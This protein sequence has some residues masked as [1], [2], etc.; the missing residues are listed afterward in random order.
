MQLARR[1]NN[2]FPAGVLVAVAFYGTRRRIT[3]VLNCYR[4]PRA[5]LPTSGS[6]LHQPTI[7]RV[8]R[9]AGAVHSSATRKKKARK[10]AFFTVCRGT[11]EN[12]K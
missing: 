5:R 12:S 6:V 10:S 1:K 9:P 2:F 4:A 3:G 7:E 11:A 8:A